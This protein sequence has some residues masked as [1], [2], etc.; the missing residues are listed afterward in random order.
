MVLAASYIFRYLALLTS[1][2][3]GVMH[4]GIRGNQ[5]LCSL[6]CCVMCVEKSLVL[7]CPRFVFMGRCASFRRGEVQE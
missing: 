5:M 7:F 2:N 4:Q 1:H 6:W 3:S